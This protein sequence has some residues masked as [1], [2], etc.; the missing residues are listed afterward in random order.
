MWRL[1]IYKKAKSSYTF[2]GEEQE[3]DYEKDISFESEDVDSL[4]G[5]VDSMSKLNAT[6]DTRYEIKK[7]GEEIAKAV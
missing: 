5:L 1:T 2:K 4:I 3:Y 6:D 7:V